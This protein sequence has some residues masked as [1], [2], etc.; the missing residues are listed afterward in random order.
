[1]VNRTIKYKNRYYRYTW[2]EIFFVIAVFTKEIGSRNFLG[3][4]FDFIS[5]P[6]YILYFVVNITKTL[7]PKTAPVALLLY[8]SVS[9]IISIALLD[10]KFDGFLKQIIPIIIILTA[11]FTI[12]KGRGIE[13]VFLLYVRIT[14]W[15]AVFGIIQ[16]ILSSFFGVL[17]LEKERGRLDSIAYEPSHYAALLMP[18][19][20]YTFINLRYFKKY[21]VVMLTALILT[22][23]LTAYLVFIALFTVA[24]FSPIYLLISAPAAYFVLFNV[25]PTLT[26][27]F[28]TR[29]NDTFATLNGTKDIFTNNLQVNGTTLS[30]FSN[31]EVAKSVLSASPLT[32]CGIG[33]HEEMYFR[34]FAGT[35]FVSNYYY[36]LNAKSAHSLSIRVL[37]ELGIVGMAL[38]IFTLIRNLIFSGKGVHF[39]ISLGC[40][41][42]FLCKSFKL[43]GYIDYGTPFFFTILILN[44]REYRSHFKKKKIG[45]APSKRP[46]DLPLYPAP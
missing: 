4:D 43:G 11:S 32:G 39:A 13:Q 16:V 30:F 1:M 17:I 18:A 35:P 8:L 28:S 9:S 20:I 5:Y 22:F 7:N 24:R 19:L 27:N 6:F 40:L 10:L 46:G 44:A 25:L 12:L 33:G 38:Y 3:I 42:H 14:Y 26:T 31:F 36:G 15:T 41:G 2:A 34:H 23:N 37:S 21:F 29:F 45:N